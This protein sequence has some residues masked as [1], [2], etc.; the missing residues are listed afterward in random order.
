M[1]EM[2][3]SATSLRLRADL[4][5]ATL[6][7]IEHLDQSIGALVPE[8]D[9]PG[10][11]LREI[12]NLER[13]ASDH[14]YPLKAVLVGVKDLIHADGLATRAGSCLPP[15]VIAGEE[16]AILKL[17]KNPTCGGLVLG[18]TTTDEFA[19]DH[20]PGTRNPLDH[21]RTPGGSSAGSAAAVAGGLCPIALGTQTSASVIAPAAFCGVL[22]FKPSYGRVS[23]EGIFPVAPS[24]DTVGI[25]SR[26][27]GLM[28]EFAAALIHD[29]RNVAAG[30]PILG[31]P[32]G[33]YLDRLPAY[34]WSEPFWKSLRHLEDQGFEVKRIPFFR[35][36]EDT[37]DVFQAASSLIYGEMARVQ[38]R[39]LNSHGH[40]LRPLT[41]KAIEHGKTILDGDVSRAQ[42]LAQS[43]RAEI[44]TWMDA[45]G[46]D[47]VLSPSQLGPAPLLES[48]R[49]SWGHT[50]TMWTFAG[51]PCLTVP[52]GA[53]NGMP[54]G[55]QGIARFYD[56]ERLLQWMAMLDRAGLRELQSSKPEYDSL[57]PRVPQD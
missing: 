14:S 31:V 43:L 57:I 34:G 4:V 30:K 54:V 15:G 41:K 12:A 51:M 13:G 8:D 29:W 23:M 7:A 35:S 24:L 47:V 27:S 40:L 38:E 39:Y 50:T 44:D 49:T 11:I 6:P 42:I 52:G 46:V 53:L 20:P 32:E 16:A 2:N 56:D 21:A 3:I 25:L 45:Q 33:S 1:N 10:R 19:Y 37:E 36:A 48:G 26:D 28:G 55:L 17:V 22:G 18:K 9:R 5:S